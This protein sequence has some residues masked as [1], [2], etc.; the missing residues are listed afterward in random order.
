MVQFSRRWYSGRCRSWPMH[1]SVTGMLLFEFEFKF[2]YCP[3]INLAWHID[4]TYVATHVTIWNF[5]DRLIIFRIRN[6]EVPSPNNMMLNQPTPICMSAPSLYYSTPSNDQSTSSIKV[7][8]NILPAVIELVKVWPEA[9]VK[10]WWKR[11]RWSNL[12]GHFPPTS[13]PW[14]TFCMSD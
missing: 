9:L 5:A 4:V 12:L 2:T 8:S 11:C 7:S 13:L 3:L 14:C 6:D 10:F 1:M